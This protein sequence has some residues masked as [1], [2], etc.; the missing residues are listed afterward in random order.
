MDGNRF[1]RIAK[2]LA[3]TSRRQALKLVAAGAVGASL[4]RLGLGAK[5]ADTRGEGERCRD[6]RDCRGDLRCCNDRCRNTLND[7]RFCGSCGNRCGDREVCRNGG[8]FRSCTSQQAGRCELSACGPLCGCNPEVNGDGVCQRTG[9]SCT[10]LRA[11]DRTADCRKGFVCADSGCCKDKPRV[12]VRPCDTVNNSAAA[13]VSADR[14]AGFTP[15][16]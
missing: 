8:C 9:V 11:C 6:T 15:A 12:C 4:S 10:D 1:D 13:V 14:E 2:S 7:P 16:S 3:G 5:A